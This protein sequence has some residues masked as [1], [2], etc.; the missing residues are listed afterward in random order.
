MAPN[1]SGRNSVDQPQAMQLAELAFDCASQILVPGG[2]FLCKV[3]QGEGID[4]FVKV[5]KKSFKTVKW[6]KPKSSRPRS[7]EI[8]LLGLGFVGYTA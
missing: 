1:L 6:R 2:A 7:R 4:A 8:Y 5:L 3:F